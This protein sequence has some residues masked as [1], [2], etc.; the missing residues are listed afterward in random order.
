MRKIGWSS[1][2]KDAK[3]HSLNLRVVT[4][5]KSFKR[6]LIGARFGRLVV[7]GF[8]PDE[9]RDTRWFCRC[10]CG[11]VKTVIGQAMI[12]GLTKSCGCMHVDVQRAAKTKHGS[13]GR[14]SKDRT[15][16]YKTWASMMARCEWSKSSSFDR[17]GARGIRVCDRWHNFTNF[18]EDMGKRPKGFSIERI[19]NEKGYEPGNCKWASR[20]EQSLN[21]SRTIKVLHNGIAIPVYLLCERLGLSRHAVRSRAARRGNDYVSALKSLGVDVEPFK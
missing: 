10:D 18:L 14:T 11:K 12:R 5:A 4:M 17:Y 3:I 8:S 19:D 15:A 21:T 9:T 20:I 7:E 6:D 16:E 1:T 2:D 13:A